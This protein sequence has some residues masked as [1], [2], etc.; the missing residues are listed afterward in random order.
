ML[1][2]FSLVQALVCASFLA[3]GALLQYTLGLRS[4]PATIAGQGVAELAAPPG[5]GGDEPSPQRP[6]G[7]QVYIDIGSNNGMSVLRFLNF[8]DTSGPYDAST[9]YH[10]QGQWHIVMLEA[11][12]LHA[13]RLQGMAQYLRAFGHTVQLL[14]PSALSTQHGGNITF[15]LDTPDAAT[16]AASTVAGANSHS[17]HEVVVPTVDIAYLCNSFV[18]GGLME[19]DYVVVKMDVEGSEYDILLQAIE[20]GIPALWDEL[21]VEFHEDNNWVLR[22]TSLEQ[23]AR[24]KRGVIE[25]Q[26]TEQFGLKVGTWDR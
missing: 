3:L 24:E 1:P 8:P 7:T 6:I 26:M 9:P 17:G 13:Q 11:N 2:Q 22:G 15:F 5:P 20:A 14:A 4:S 16:Y 10:G 12:P 19:H 25:R 23:E 21:Y 18:L